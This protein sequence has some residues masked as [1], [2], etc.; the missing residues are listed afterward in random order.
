M[1]REFLLTTK[2]ALCLWYACLPYLQAA[3]HHLKRVRMFPS[4]NFLPLSLSST[5]MHHPT[6][7]HPHLAPPIHTPHSIIMWL[8]CSDE[9]VAREERD[10]GKILCATA[11]SSCPLATTRWSESLNVLCGGRYERFCRGPVK[12]ASMKT[13]LKRWH[14]L[15]RWLPGCRR[16]CHVIRRALNEQTT[17]QHLNKSAPVT[18]ITV[19]FLDVLPPNV[20]AW[21]VNRY[22]TSAERLLAS[23]HPPHHL[24]SHP[25]PPKARFVTAGNGNVAP[26]RHLLCASVSGRASRLFAPDRVLL[27]PSG[28]P[29]E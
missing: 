4:P 28:R 14:L 11:I 29:L 15:I 17:N 12:D 8:E 13:A 10:L 18:S 9:E 16:A 25:A 22:R 23:H 3:R 24:Q 21:Y 27:V 7:L 19:S 6:S 1:H 20:K 26:A 2:N 5:M